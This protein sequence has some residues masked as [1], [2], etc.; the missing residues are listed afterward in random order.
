MEVDE[1][2]E[3]PAVVNN[4]I[5]EETVPVKLVNN[6][7]E[8]ETVPVKP[9][10]SGGV[11]RSILS[12][13]ELNSI[14]SE[15]AKRIESHYEHKLEE[16]LTAKALCET[17]K[18]N[19][20]QLKADY[21]K[22]I[23]DL[24]LK[25]QDESSKYHFSQQSFKELRLELEDAK[26]ELT[27]A[28][29]KVKQ[30]DINTAR[31]RRERNEAVNERDTLLN[32]VERKTL[33]VERLQADVIGLEQK[34]KSANITKCEALAKLE[35]IQ[36][37]E[38]SL[39]FKEKRMDKEMSMRDNQIQKLTE[40]LNRALQ[41]L[42]N[43]RRD[44][45]FNALTTE[46]KLAEKT[47]ELKIATAQIA[48][49]SQQNQELS[50]KAEDLATKL[51]Q[52][53]EE[54]R[55]MM[56]HYRKELQSQTKLCELYQED[57]ED[58]KKQTEEL[59]TAV[60]ELKK[61]L[62][63]ATDS[64]GKLETQQKS[65]VMK[66]EKELEL[67]DQIIQQL[68]DE[69][70]HANELLKMAREESL[71]HAVEKLAP[72]A[73]A[74]SR[75]I[76]SGMTLTEL[77]TMY[78]KAA[79]DL[80][81]EKK[82]NSKLQLQIKNI[83]QE[84]EERAPELTRQQNEYQNLKDANEEMTLQL[85]KLIE[86]NAE[87]RSELGSMQD[88][89]RYLD[90]ENKKFKLER[91][92]LSRQICHLLREIEQ[93]RGG[94]ASEADQSISSDMSANE[95]IS[96]KLVTF[97]DIQELQENNVK[98]LLVVRDFSA[99]LEEL[100]IAQ[101]AMS[102]ATFEAKIASY[103][104]R[105][106]EMQE[107][108]EYQTQ[109][110][111]QCIQQ[112][113]RYKKMYHDAMRSY[114]A[115]GGKGNLGASLN[116][117][118]SGD[119]VDTAMDEELPSAS[120][121]SAVSSEAVAEKDKKISEL[122]GKGKQI[123][124]MLT[125]L[126]EE[127]DNYR[128][129]KLTN[130]KMMNEQFDS[131]RTELR[132][133][134]SK[135]IKLAATVEYNNEQIKIQQKN[136]ATYKKQISTLEE[137]NKNYE[138]TISKQEATIMF[139]KDET[140]SAQSKLARAEVQVENLKHECRILKD[141][142]SRLQTEREIL[143]R[144][145]QNQN[146]L[147]NNLE[148]IKVT[149]ERSEAEGRIR[150]ETRLDET[151]R[152]CSALRRRL[153]EEQDRFRE[154][155]THL[156]RQ[157]QTAKQR[158]EEEMA[159]AETVQAELKNTRD[160]LEIKSRKID[161][162]NKK[163]QETLSPND[164][165]NPMTQANRKIRELEQ[166]V[167]EADIEIESLRKELT[168]AKEHVKQYCNMSESSE[169]E[170]KD[171]NELYTTY[172]TQTET[173]LS[174]LKKS[175]TDLKAQVEELKTENSL[176]KTGEQLTS[177]TD[178]ESEL[179]KSQVEL[180]EALEKL[181]ENNKD[182]RELREKNN[183][184]LEQ[185]QQAEQ[186]YANE[187]VQHSSDIQQLANLKEEVQKTKLQF[188]EL[189][190]ARDQAV[191]R[192]K[193]SE[194]CWKNREEI[195]RKEIDQ[196]EERLEDLN[197]QNAA[198]HDQIQSLSTKLS[199][200]AAQS[201]E[202]KP[203]E[204]ADESMNDSTIEDSSML[205]K[206]I[207]DEEKRSVDQLL[208]IIKYLR[209]EKDI[210]VAQFDILRSEN[211]RVR[212]EL[213]MFQKK[214]DEAQAELN[215]EREKSET[216]VVTTA[217]HE[218]ILRKLETL[219]AITDSNR[220]LREE[221]DA[222]NKKIKDLSDRLLKAEDELFPLQEKVRELSVK[223]ESAT[224]EN[225]TLRVEATRWR[226]RANLLVERSNK[227]SPED[228]KRLQTERENLAKMLTNEKELLK[229]SNEELNSIRIEKGKLEAEISNMTKQLASSSDQNKKYAEELDVLR[230]A[231]AKMTVEIGEVK[232]TLAKRDEELKK[233]TDEL[234]GKEEQL[235]DAKSKEQQIRKIAKRYKD[236]YIELKKTVDEKEGENGKAAGEAGSTEASGE[237]SNNEQQ[238][239]ITENNVSELK[240][241]I[242]SS[243]E[244]IENLKTENET[245][246]SK[247]EKAERNQDILKDVKHRIL[248][249]TE[250]KNNVTRELNNAKAQ[251]QSLEHVRDENELL[252]SQFEGRISRLTKENADQDKE[253]TDAITR[254]T[255]ENEQ[256]NI[257]MNQLT[258]QLGLQ[259]V[260]K[261][262]T[263]A[264]GSSE[265]GS[266][267]SPRTAN[268]KPIPGPSAQQSATV[269]PRR[270]S[271][272][273]LA[274]IRPMSVQ[275]SSRT[276][277]V[278]PT[279]QTSNN[280]AIV[281]GSS[282][283]SSSSNTG[284]SSSSVTALVPPQQQVH[285]TGG[286][287][288]S[289][290]SMSSSPTSSHT[291]YMPATSSANVAVAAVPPMGT[292]STSSSTA[293]S[294]S[295][296]ENE[297]IPAQQA[298]E[299][300]P[301]QMH[302]SAGQP[303]QAVALVSPH[304]EGTPQTGNVVAQVAQSSPQIQQPVQEQQNPAPSTSGS[305]SS[306]AQQLAL[307]SHHQASTS[308]NT[309]TTSQAAAG[310]KRPRDI[311]GDSSTDTVE[312]MTEKSAPVNK[313]TRMQGGETF[314]GVSES[315]LE[316]E[317]QVPTSSQRDQ[318]DDIIVVDSEEDE[319]GMADDGTAD[320]GT[321]E[322]DDGPFEGY[323]G[324]EAYEQDE[325]EIAGNYDEGEGPDIDEDNVQSANNEVDVDDDN[326]VP[327]QSGT[328]STTS[329]A[330]VASDVE[331]SS[332]IVGQSSNAGP[333]TSSDGQPTESSSQPTSNEV[334]QIQSI[335]SGSGEPSGPST[336][337][338]TSTAASAASTSASTTSSSTSSASSSAT[339]APASSVTSQA[340][341]ASPSQSRRQVN[342][343]ARQQ[344]QQ[345]VL[346]QQ[347]YEESTD[348]RI[349]PS[350]PT[351]YVPRRTDGF[352]DAVSSPHPQVPNARFTFIETSRAS[353]AAADAQLLPEGIDDTRMDL[354][355]LDESSGG[356]PTGRSVPTTPHQTS[357]NE[358]ER[359]VIHG[360]SSSVPIDSNE[361]EQAGEQLA[362]CGSSV[363]VVQRESEEPVAG[364]SGIAASVTSGEC[365]GQ[366]PEITVSAAEDD[367]DYSITDSTTADQ[368]TNTSEAT[369]AESGRSD[370][371]TDDDDLDID[372][373]VDRNRDAES[374]DGVTSEGEKHPAPNTTPMDEG[375]EADGLETPSS[376][377]RSRSVPRTT[378]RRGRRFGQRGST[379][380]NMPWSEGRQLNRSGP[381][382]IQ[383]QQ[384]QQQQQQQRSPVGSPNRAFH[385][386]SPHHH[387]MHQQLSPPTRRNTR[388][389]RTRR[390]NMHYR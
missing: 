94:Y 222:L 221:R 157:M 143:N 24:T 215:T 71:E 177:S 154:L 151:S 189:K 374:G 43:V 273:P 242:T 231:G 42:Q 194:E 149:M 197:S 217:K 363:E 173:E 75:L 223:I 109:M 301:S 260:S 91:S 254:L 256:L 27:Q 192:V 350:T 134:S 208:Q 81:I 331:T 334:Q 23:E 180:K 387:H 212:S 307:S 302:V 164:E 343:L 265:K 275:A 182:L 67:K 116:G 314:Q 359:A 95:V 369:A 207:S 341:A 226:Q 368:T 201:L 358:H 114:N 362:P 319:E 15:T 86:E 204:K 169:K 288:N 148:M 140:M 279:S 271:E 166:K 92:D 56:D 284:T 357:P 241:Q 138:T 308:S 388:S 268:V 9:I 384:Q 209:K 280:V 19:V 54:T 158:M 198:L 370:D 31:F 304:I 63:D 170:L 337:S 382:A 381:S 64:Y 190:Q 111:Q 181:S 249:L 328:S 336:S 156:E 104:K 122:E 236:S 366:V 340:V 310:H 58:N 232:S 237:S 117:S 351:L 243:Q 325:P 124:Q 97:S 102:Q 247:L 283:S 2:P 3:V 295:Q 183:S 60:S 290:E 228:W 10:E 235:T 281:Q 253:K 224:S 74:T 78:V 262:S 282:S 26:Q 152:E 139:L 298:N 17:A 99:K 316:V 293:E 292:A 1:S 11:L 20:E 303:S 219:N 87:A 4:A 356:R 269:T 216:G 272:T 185:L 245:L 296:Q 318:E 345:L 141:A 49:L 128:K 36:S 377:T 66:H 246:K 28:K 100:E 299:P 48:H 285:T 172:K 127:Y 178:S 103:N 187:M 206:S 229:K 264:S 161:D 317:Y 12:T 83:V 171:L 361:A 162:L 118:L 135:N 354:S 90:S 379:S 108:Q 129:E 163:L 227:T 30:N 150:L 16:F 385:H 349:V 305:S 294:S 353:S 211:V 39:D 333:S 203:V 168:T 126:K 274:S 155:T 276:A 386:G 18:T 348:D 339:A 365:E 270:G 251:I 218:E 93:M 329:S 59:G 389:T 313:R 193:T 327:N 37:K 234:A 309:V 335:S 46:A 248:S 44:Q 142:E 25:Y 225:S 159:I 326:E 312:Q 277:A 53:N 259:Q 76:K 287:N 69:L 101:N 323:D 376:N 390:S 89:V 65:Q 266:T 210:A 355:Q 29:E 132:E 244:E 55:K 338:A 213:M 200:T 5:V 57:C 137:R 255:R 144:E 14:P 360:D 85:N 119:N 373:D 196:L 130:D 107:T 371:R 147:L 115:V 145:R 136:V 174:A 45:N 220:G 324:E 110:M 352:S 315:G 300:G 297:S 332:T 41:D 51:L 6:A 205:N 175:E 160:E 32:A 367:D 263:S 250:M 7:T 8:E 146:L 96:K 106:Q 38:F 82:E 112:R 342:P 179:H 375:S 322:A 320:E 22:Q 330:Q 258:R 240:S 52:Q 70:K 123:Q 47:E 252:K 344:Q 267:E 21:E 84:L 120:T 188:D 121:V 73:A 125:N 133:L 202:Q 239:K 372:M 77:Y 153:Q 378:T 88:K 214:F 186:K 230:Q 195:M 98:L 383:M 257:R 191:E 347:N 113:D 286:S 68:K 165:D 13:E 176:K 278:L 79:E 62:N 199:I 306:N 261:P 321:A 61:L 34:L 233:L 184:L 346:M 238:E 364:P 72:S 50:E 311:E 131:M 40:D 33:E 380:R 289:N 80:Q 35:E 105:L 291:D 167:S